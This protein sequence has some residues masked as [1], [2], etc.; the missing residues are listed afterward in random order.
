MVKSRLIAR[1]MTFL[2]TF[3]QGLQVFYLNHLIWMQNEEVINPQSCRTRNLLVFELSL[4]N[5]GGD[6]II[7]M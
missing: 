3:V 2:T 6:M 4:E 1:Q 7:S 5:L